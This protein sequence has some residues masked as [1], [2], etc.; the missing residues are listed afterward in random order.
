MAAPRFLTRNKGCRMCSS[1][2]KETKERCFIQAYSSRQIR[3]NWKAVQSVEGKGLEIYHRDPD[4][5]R[6]I[7]V[8]EGET[9]Q[10]EADLF[11]DLITLPGIQNVSLVAN[12]E[13]TEEEQQ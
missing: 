4:A 13:D 8:I 10:S 7:A 6:F 12:L 11:K 1:H 2:T 9:I 3:E 5:E